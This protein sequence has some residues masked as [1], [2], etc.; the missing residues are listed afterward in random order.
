MPPK[1]PRPRPARM[2]NCRILL[3]FCK[4]VCCRALR[5]NLSPQETQQ[6]QHEIV[7]GQTVL[8]TVRINNKYENAEKACAYV[9]PKTRK[10]TLKSEGKKAPK[11]C[12]EFTCL[13]RQSILAMIEARLSGQERGHAMRYDP[14]I[15]HMSPKELAAAR[16]EV[17]RL[18]RLKSQ[19]KGT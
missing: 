14:E 5:V 16:K 3:P 17:E 7:D 1:G 2:P 13:D 8:K 6:Y 15:G 18:R 4:G 12:E 9:D 10:C 11:V 19:R